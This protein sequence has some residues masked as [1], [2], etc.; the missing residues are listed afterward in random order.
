MTKMTTGKY[1]QHPISLQRPTNGLK[2]ENTSD[3]FQIV[4]SC[5]YKIKKKEMLHLTTG[6]GEVNLTS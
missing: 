6:L 5:H 2:S 4:N 3:D 1:W